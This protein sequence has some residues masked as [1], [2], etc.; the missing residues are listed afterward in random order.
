M[1]DERV[2]LQGCDAMVSCDVAALQAQVRMHRRDVSAT[3][4]ALLQLLTTRLVKGW[5][6][7]QHEQEDVIRRWVPA[8]CM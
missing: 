6:G 5:L 3:R 4:K 1:H 7:L 8:C 2:C